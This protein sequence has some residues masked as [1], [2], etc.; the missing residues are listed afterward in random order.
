MRTVV[1][2]R[3]YGG[4]VC[5]LQLV[6]LC[7]QKLYSGDFAVFERWVATYLNNWASCD[8][9]C[10]HTVGTFLE[11]CGFIGELINRWA[12][13]S[14]RWMKRAAAVSLIIP[15]RNGNSFRRY[16]LL[17][18]LCCRMEMTWCREGY[19]WMLKSASQAYQK[20]CLSML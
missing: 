19:G 3:L 20:R 16:S 17:Q 8:T 4:V 9:L 11:M 5:S 2:I 6:V 7:E 1:E 15:A 10:N 14:N 12:K 13:S 18:I